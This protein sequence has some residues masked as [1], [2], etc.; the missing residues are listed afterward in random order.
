MK[1][2]A[3]EAREE[4]LTLFSYTCLAI[5]GAAAGG[6]VLLIVLVALIII[7]IRYKIVLHFYLAMWKQ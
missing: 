1:Y 5:I 2:V 3:I 7:F 4:N 6:G